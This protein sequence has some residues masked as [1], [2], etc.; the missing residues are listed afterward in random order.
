MNRL[1]LA[2]L[3][4][5]SSHNLWASPNSLQDLRANI[6][7]AQASLE[8][9]RDVSK[10]MSKVS[11]HRL[12]RDAARRYGIEAAVVAT[13]IKIESNFDACARSHVGAEGMMQLMPETSRA[14]GVSD[15]YDAEQSVMGG[16]RY[17][18]RR[19]EMTNQNLSLAGAL[20]NGGDRLLKV[21]RLNWPEETKGYLRKIRHYYPIYEGQ[22]WVKRTPKWISN[23][24]RFRCDAV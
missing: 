19:L 24:S 14:L 5:F 8:R 9:N 3:M 20:Y 15:P 10:E 13:I 23:G 7:A 2:I 4:M 16:T 17:L 22:G 12:I 11:L 18:A 6:D 21:S 1:L